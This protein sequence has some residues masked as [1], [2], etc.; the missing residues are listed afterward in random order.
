[1]IFHNF[2]S[3]TWFYYVTTYNLHLPCKYIFVTATPGVSPIISWTPLLVSIS[4]EGQ[5]EDGLLRKLILHLELKSQSALNNVMNQSPSTLAPTILFWW[6]NL[7]LI[8]RKG[9]YSVHGNII[10]LWF[11]QMVMFK[12][13]LKTRFLLPPW[14]IKEIINCISSSKLGNKLTY[15]KVEWMRQ[16]RF[17]SNFKLTNN[18]R[19]KPA[20]DYCFQ[21]QSPPKF[22]LLIG[23]H[24]LKYPKFR[25]VYSS[26]ISADLWKENMTLISRLY[27]KNN[28]QMDF[29]D[30]TW[31]NIFK[32]QCRKRRFARWRSTKL[33]PEY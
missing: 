5:K 19:F 2:I 3:F 20:L 12:G 13:H 33:N 24:Y 21:H 29:E 8:F 6:N 11:L 23:K 4:Q 22:N 27:E 18:I 26:V 15:R 25:L 7:C 9:K 1:V 14:S 28:K 30:E 31:R 17:F 32:I 16:L 10:L